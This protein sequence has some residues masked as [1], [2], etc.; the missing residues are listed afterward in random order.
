MGL[1]TLGFRILRQCIQARRKVQG[2]TKVRLRELRAAG[3]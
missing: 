1:K 2:K 3:L